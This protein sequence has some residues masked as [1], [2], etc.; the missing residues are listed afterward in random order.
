[1][2]GNIGRFGG[3]PRLA[4]LQALTLPAADVPA[5]PTCR[6]GACDV[7]LSETAMRRF[8]NEVGWSSSGAARQAN[9]LIR[10]MILELVLAY[11]ANGNAALGRYDDGREPLP[12]ADQFR[13]LLAAADPLPA[14]VPALLAY[15]DTY[16]RGRPAGVED[17][18]YWSVVDFGLKHTIRVSHAMI[19]PLAAN[20]PG[21]V[22]AIAIKQ[23]YASHYF[24]TTL[25]LRFLVDDDRRAGR[26]GTSLISI[27]RSRSD[28]MTGFK[29]WLLRPIISRRSR[30]A[31]GGYLE[32]VKR[33]IERPDPADVVAQALL[34]SVR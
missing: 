20:S 32:H 9:E 14:P 16:P 7:K 30:A 21:V 13:A 31:V 27:M 33:Q 15:L 8:R 2:Q 19:Y 34:P 1:V 29:G 22:Y 24:H 25:E 3:S 5:L 4:D 10:T 26:R 11:Q 6:P 17:F 18:F 23:L 28:G 12:V